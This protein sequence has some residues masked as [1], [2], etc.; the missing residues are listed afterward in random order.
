MRL[1]RLR[2]SA[3]LGFHFA[4]GR[5]VRVSIALNERY[6]GKRFDTAEE[7]VL[8]RRRNADGECGRS[9]QTSD[10]SFHLAPVPGITIRIDS[11]PLRS[12]IAQ[13]VCAVRFASVK[14]VRARPLFQR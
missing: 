5:L 13:V 12:K 1:K 7:P 10:L 4:G 8:N 3:G 6:T 9:R 14:E 2:G 11:K